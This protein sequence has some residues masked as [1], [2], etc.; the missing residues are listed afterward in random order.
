M[1][2]VRDFLNHSAE[3]EAYWASVS[4]GLIEQ[5][6]PPRVPTSASF[7]PKMFTRSPV[8]A[9]PTQ[10]LPVSGPVLQQRVASDGAV[11]ASVDELYEAAT[12]AQSRLTAVLDQTVPKDQGIQV[13]VRRSTR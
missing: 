5:Q 12:A 3:I 6:V 2:N 13:E 10:I 7:P 8:S 4:K 11:V 1:E 9:P